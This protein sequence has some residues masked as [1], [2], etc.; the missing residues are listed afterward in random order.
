METLKTFIY[1]IVFITL[2]LIGIISLIMIWF[3]SISIIIHK[4]NEKFKK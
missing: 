2:M 3:Y 1:S 4:L